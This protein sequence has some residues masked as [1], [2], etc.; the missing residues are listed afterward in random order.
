MVLNVVRIGNLNPLILMLE[1]ME[2]TL[3]H[4]IYKMDLLGNIALNVVI[5]E[6]YILKSPTEDPN[7]CF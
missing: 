4:R 7:S 6:C 3:A 2:I 1:T 5:V